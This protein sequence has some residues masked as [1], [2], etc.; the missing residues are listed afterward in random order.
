MKP[1]GPDY[2]KKRYNQVHPGGI[3]EWPVVNLSKN[4]DLFIKEV[5]LSSISRIKS[6]TK[7]RAA[8]IE[9]IENTLFRE[10][11]RIKRNPWA[12]D[13]PDES[14]FLKSVNAKLLE[15]SQDENQSNVD[16]TLDSIL[17][18]MVLRYANEIAGNFKKSRF[19][20]A[21]SIV[22]FGLSR[23][24]N[25]SRARGFWSIFSTKYQLQDKVQITGEVEQLRTMSTKG[26]IIMVPTH[27]SNLDSILIGWVI[28]ALGLPA[29]IY[30]A[31][32]NLFNIKI[33]AYFMNSLGAYKVDRRKKIL[34]YLQTLKS[35]SSLAI[36]KG[37]H[38]LFF[39]GGTRS[40][41]GNIEQRLKL[42]LLSTAIEAQR[43][44]YQKGKRDGLEKIFIVPVTINYNFVLEAPDLIKQY[45]K[46]K[47]QERYYVENDEYSSSYKTFAFLFKFFTKGSNISVSIGKCM[48]VLGN[49]VNEDGQSFDKHNRLVDTQE[50][51]TKDGHIISHNQQREDEY[52]RMLSSRIVEEFHI[53]NKVFASHLVAFTAF[54]II[55]KR[56]PKLDLYNLLR[57]PEEDQEIEYEDFKIV[58]EK[59]LNKIYKLKENGKVNI[60]PNLTGDIDEIIKLGVINVGM[61]HAKRAIKLTKGGKIVSEDLNLLYYYHNRLKGYNLER[62]VE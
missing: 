34:I 17:E 26:T 31:G 29:F 54:Q 52:T 59:L 46:M 13:P 20:M 21:R 57:V 56:F 61:F 27:F 23:L 16:E 49:Y 58:F 55:E 12:V 32:L 37:C 53:I 22:T 2:V 1:E 30:G 43:V 48:D 60:S 39:P 36:Q 41:S 14:D 45:L 42:G 51:F 24:L 18:E 10:K 28:S 8:L 47:G 5:T 3:N 25:A 19:R 38:S 44:N 40:R 9:E 4:R 62:H 6:M 35:Y 11:L 33:F 7:N 50:Y 15:I